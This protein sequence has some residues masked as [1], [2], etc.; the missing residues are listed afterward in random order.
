[1]LEGNQP[2]VLHARYTS[3]AALSQK[4]QLRSQIRI[5]SLVGARDL[6][7]VAS[8]SRTVSGT[9]PPVSFRPL[10]RPR[11]YEIDLA[12]VLA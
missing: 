5:Q 3:A 12:P 8:R 6:N 10:D 2:G 4:E 11:E 9:C 1:M 7:P